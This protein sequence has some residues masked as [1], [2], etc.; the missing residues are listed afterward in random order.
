MRCKK[1]CRLP[2]WS[3]ACPSS[4]RNR[5]AT[6]ASIANSSTAERPNWAPSKSIR[7]RRPKVKV[8]TEPTWNRLPF[9]RWRIRN[10]PTATL[11]TVG[12]LRPPPI[13]RKFR[14]RGYRWRYRRRA[15]AQACL[16]AKRLFAVVQYW[17]M[18]VLKH[19]PTEVAV[20]LSIQDWKGESRGQRGCQ[21]TVVGHCRPPALLV[22]IIDTNATYIERNK[23]QII[24]NDNQRN[25]KN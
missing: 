23:R 21:P 1:T 11:V 4:Y 10:E 2:E 6:P 25:K 3:W 12:N 22:P 18:P 15:I 8:A 20:L 19:L 7:P 24:R 9:R 17:P 13:R 16:M 5:K 14:L